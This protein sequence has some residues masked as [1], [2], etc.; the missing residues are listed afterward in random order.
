MLYVY[1]NAIV[2]DLQASL[3]TDSAIPAVKVVDPASVVNLAAQMHND[4]IQYPVIALTRTQ[5]VSM[6]E[7]R[8]NF[9]SRHVGQQTVLDPDTNIF[10]YERSLPIKL[11]YDLTVITTNMIDMDEIV[12]ELLFKYISMYYLVVDLPY[13]C[14]RSIRFGICID[15]NTQIESKSSVHEYL[16]AGQ[17]YQTSIPLVCEGAVLI[18]YRPVKLQRLEHQLGAKVS[19]PS[20]HT[21]SH[22]KYA[23]SE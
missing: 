2:A 13:E 15:S 8:M 22:T 18:S 10:Y 20:K 11:S 4:E 23:D 5:P 3:N 17:L 9:T 1:D 12:K 6:D 14:K 16:S 19:V 21:L 7:V